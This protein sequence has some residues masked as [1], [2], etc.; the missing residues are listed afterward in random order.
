[1]GVYKKIRF[2]GPTSDLNSHDGIQWH[3]NSVVGALQEIP[4]Q[5]TPEMNELETDKQD[6]KFWACNFKKQRS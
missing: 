2:Y 5:K 4:G 3:A 1:M 6:L